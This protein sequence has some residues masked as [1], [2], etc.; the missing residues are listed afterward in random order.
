MSR[1]GHTDYR[2]HLQSAVAASA[3][4]YGY[5][6]TIWTSGAVASHERG[7]P[8]TGDALLFLLGAVFGFGL[9]AAIAYGR[10]TEIFASREH[11]MVRLWGGF[12]LISVG[13]AIAASSLVVSAV[14]SWLAWPL[15]GLIATFTYLLVIAGQFTIADSRG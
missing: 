14:E 5:T 11:G 3:A 8:T 12:H 1:R 15:V 2:S 9:A 4:P 7:L 6:L 10:P 13:L